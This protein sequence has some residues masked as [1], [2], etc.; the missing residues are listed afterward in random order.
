[1]HRFVEGFVLQGGDVTRGDG[2]GGESICTSSDPRPQLPYV[3]GL[4][5]SY[6]IVA[7]LKGI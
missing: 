2:S 3:R 1:M 6:R 4:V 5:S 7:E